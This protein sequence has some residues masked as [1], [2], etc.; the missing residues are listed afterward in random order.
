M[1][2]QTSLSDCQCGAS[3]SSGKG[4]RR[5]KADPIPMKFRV[6]LADYLRDQ[7]RRENKTMVAFLEGLLEDHRQKNEIYQ[8]SESDSA[9]PQ[10]PKAP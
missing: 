4:R 9:A 6:D 10:E 1:N 3:K 7:S 5:L 8:E 2:E